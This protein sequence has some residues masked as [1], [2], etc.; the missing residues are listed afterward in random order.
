MALDQGTIQALGEL[1][2]KWSVS[3][4]EVIRRAVKRAKEEADREASLPSPLDALN[5]LQ[6]GGGLTLQEAEAFREDV[7]QERQAKHYW[8]ES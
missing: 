5:W 4:A 7:G 2:D 1:A 8:W 6:S 3:K